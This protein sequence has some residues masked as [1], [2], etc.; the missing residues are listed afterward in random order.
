MYDGSIAGFYCCVFES[1][2][3]RQIPCDI[4][5]SHQAPYTL[6]PQ[7]LITTDSQKA[8]RVYRSIPLKISQQALRLV[9]V[10]FL[11]CMKQKEL[12]LLRF[13]LLA[14]RCNAKIMQMLAHPLV[15]PLLAAER[16]IRNE[17]HLLRGFIRFADYDG[18]LA[19][20]ITPKNFVLPLIANHF[21]TRFS[22][23]DFLIFDKTHH[24]A[25]TY[26]NRKKNFISVKEIEFSP[27]SENENYYQA[28]WKQFYNTVAIEARDNPKCR[29]T[30]VP[31][32]YWENM[33]EM[34]D[35]L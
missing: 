13:L 10:V 32:R 8:A 18:I 24:A 4:F 12:A 26:Q 6:L 2:Y 20:S 33:T 25:L 9:E 23:E 11:S 17:S 3:S 21:I 34:K 15:A 30:Q 22:D 14:Y 1:V 19:A 31:K 7:K 5:V 35:L 28:L 27:A 16:H 29:M